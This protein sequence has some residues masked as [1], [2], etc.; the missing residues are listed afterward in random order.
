MQNLRDVLIAGGAT[1]LDGWGLTQASAVSADGRT[2]VG[3][4]RNP[5]GRNEAWVATIPEPSSLL[6]LAGA[7][8]AGVA[9]LLRHVRR[10]AARNQIGINPL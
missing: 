9:A 8:T 6:L 7:A 10:D 4:G 5:S 2:I 3:F 1:G